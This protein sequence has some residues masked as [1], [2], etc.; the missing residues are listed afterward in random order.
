MQFAIYAFCE[1]FSVGITADIVLI[2]L[3]LVTVFQLLVGSLAVVS[4][5]F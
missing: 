2:T 5:A 1:N 4:L 3:L